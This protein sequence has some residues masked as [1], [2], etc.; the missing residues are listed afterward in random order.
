[1]LRV[2]QLAWVTAEAY[3]DHRFWGQVMRVGRILGW[4]T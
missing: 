3:R 1:M 4:K 2:G